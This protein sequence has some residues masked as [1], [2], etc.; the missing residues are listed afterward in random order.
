MSTRSREQHS[1]TCVV[2]AGIGIAAHGLVF[3]FS[4]NRDAGLKA[5]AGDLSLSLSLPLSL[6]YPL[7]LSIPPSPSLS[8]FSLSSL[9]LS[10]RLSLSLSGFDG[11]PDHSAATGAF[12][13]VS[14]LT[15]LVQIALHF[16]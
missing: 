2:R 16:S 1:T 9:S 8:L 15:I 11:F 4:L 12:G 5:R 13:D 14:T 7:P 6:L 10:L 3:D